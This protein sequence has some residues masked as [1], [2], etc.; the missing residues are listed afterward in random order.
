MERFD[1]SPHL[2]SYITTTHHEDLQP[3]ISE[4]PRVVAAE[5]V[6]VKNMQIVWD[7][8]KEPSFLETDFVG[9]YMTFSTS[10]MYPSLTSNDSWEEIAATLPSG[11]VGIRE[12]AQAQGNITLDG[13]KLKVRSGYVYDGMRYIDAQVYTVQDAKKLDGIDQGRIDVLQMIGEADKVVRTRTGKWYV[14]HDEDSVIQLEKAL[15]Q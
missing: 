9:D 10:R 3:A 11:V 6:I 5:L 7:Y 1:P 14:F 2:G 8:T 12:T 13:K 15:A 4:D